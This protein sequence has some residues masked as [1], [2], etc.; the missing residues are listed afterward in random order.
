M[1]PY[2]LLLGLLSGLLPSGFLNKKT[3][4]VL[5]YLNDGLTSIK[6]SW[7]ETL[8]LVVEF[9]CQQPKRFGKSNYSKD[10]WIHKTI[11]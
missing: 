8:K 5:S 4:E 11:I 3:C 7:E 6:F 2:R 1:L 9:H 10:S